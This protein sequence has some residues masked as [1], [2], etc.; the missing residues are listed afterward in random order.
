MKV[1]CELA[2]EGID[3]FTVHAQAGTKQLNVARIIIT[4]ENHGDYELLPGPDA[5][6]Y[7]S[8]KNQLSELDRL[9]IQ[10]TIEEAVDEV[11]TRRAEAA[12]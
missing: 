12:S 7:L 5:A 8:L 1:T 3:G 9:R 11:M 6:W 2:P 4:G 10:R